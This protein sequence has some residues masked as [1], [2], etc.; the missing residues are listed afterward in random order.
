MG[1][2]HPSSGPPAPQTSA[3]AV[4]TADAAAAT[5]GSSVLGGGAWQA[6]SRLLPQVYVLLISVAAARFLGPDGMGRQS[7]IAFVELSVVMLVA[8]GLAISLTRFV[9]ETLGRREADR[10]GGLVSWA[11]RV[12]TAAAL[13]G[14]GTLVVVALGGAEPTGAW[15]LA[16][17][18]A[19][20]AIMQAIP[21]AV[22][23]GAQRWRDA[24]VVGLVTATIGLPATVGVL[25]AGGG[26]TGMFAVEAIISTAN[27]LWTTRLA[28]RLLR[29][30]AVRRT[31]DKD[32]RRRTLRYALWTTVVVVLSLIVFRRSEFFFL[33]AYS[34]DSQIAVYSIAFATA[35]AVALL[36]YALADA[37]LPAFA[38]LFGAGAHERIRSGY[39]RSLR[40]MTVAALP[41]TAG[42][43]A[44]GPEALRLVY[45]GDYSD[46]GP[47]LL[48]MAA[49][50]PLLP[51]MSISNSLLG[52][53]GKVIAPTVIAAG[54]AV[55][56]VVLALLLIP[57][58]DA[59]GA[60]L[61]NTAAQG[62]SA[63]AIVIY[64]WRAVGKVRFEPSSIARGALASAAGAGAAAGALS[65]LGG[66][67]LGLMA[68]LVV[69]CA[70]FSGAAAVIGILPA[71]DAEWL[72]T[73]G[74]PR[75]G[76][77]FERACRLVA[78]PAVAE[79]HDV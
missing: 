44:L 41:L 30:V 72:G 61:A 43:I 16:A 39:S 46:T 7:F 53:L 66:G 6:L 35:T 13:L 67:V 79:T 38:T 34:T 23:V 45:G 73:T 75:L 47:L 60:A 78:R 26:I 62:A 55:V 14:G 27:L 70:V 9:G 25:A 3:E 71:D 52:G 69:G 68:G 29:G 77:W 21:N 54:S 22:L 76:R 31:L 19:S 5:M 59:M 58:H 49:A 51:L 57:A 2:A 32:L 12:E 40:L 48:V 15:A 10:L 4:L 37:V 11:W 50:F 42:V 56:N 1:P 33:E 63:L 8:E 18:A 17:V 20:V 74:A 64:T 36:P 65:G 24:S 28:N